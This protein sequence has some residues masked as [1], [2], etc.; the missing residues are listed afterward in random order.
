[1]TKLESFNNWRKKQS[2]GRGLLCHFY[3]ADSKNQYYDKADYAY[4]NLAAK[5]RGW[6]VKGTPGHGIKSKRGKSSQM[7]C[8][9]CFE[10]NKEF[11]KG[12]KSLR[13]NGNNKF[14]FGVIFNKRKLKD[15]FKVIDVSIERPARTPN[16]N[17]CHYFDNAYA[18]YGVL[19]PFNYCDVVRIEIPKT[20]LNQSPIVALS[21][22]LVL[23]ILCKKNHKGKV[24]RLLTAKKMGRTK[25]F[26]LL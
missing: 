1:M 8:L 4:F 7:P 19:K 11:Y 3:I 17:Q 26:S 24:S 16:P 2:K 15:R 22:S 6:V 25:I 9:N 13:K 12:I 10:V 20:M 18:R 21:H 14:E 5:M 23:G